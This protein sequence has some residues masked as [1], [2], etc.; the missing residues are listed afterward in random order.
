MLQ[1]TGFQGCEV[2]VKA[3]LTVEHL[4]RS[5]CLLG[6]RLGL[7]TFAADRPIVTP[8][9][10]DAFYREIAPI[11]ASA[12]STVLHEKAFGDRRLA[13]AAAAARDGAYAFVGLPPQVPFTFIEGRPCIPGGFAGV[14]VWTVQASSTVQCRPV[15]AGAGVGGMLLVTDLG[16]ALFLSAVSGRTA[17]GPT[18]AIVT[19]ECRAM[20]ENARQVLLDQGFSLRDVAR[21]WIFVDRLLDWYDDLNRVRVAFFND[22]GLRVGDRNGFLPASTG[23]QGRHPSGAEVVVDVLAV[24][25]ARGAEPVLHPIR[26][27]RQDAA[28]CYG[29]AFSRGMRV[30][31]AESSLVLVSGTAS[32]DLQGRTRYVDDAQGQ[33]AE[34]YL[35]TAAVLRAEGAGLPDVA[36]AV[37]YFKDAAC[38]QVHCEMADL[39]LLPDVP[40]ID[41]IADV[42]RDDLL[43]EMEATAVTR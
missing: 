2:P 30:G 19:D 8:A 23:I 11:V 37:R 15:T 16:S 39:G 31:S 43:F 17:A 10:L 12:G 25:A 24:A 22:N 13:S 1:T 40:A 6:A 34:S 7:H 42:C 20:F 33:I 14:Q 18:P 26:S 28:L 32:I 3:W 38:W 27:P 5:A 9:D 29:S 4:P 41:V 35:N 36:M 21:T